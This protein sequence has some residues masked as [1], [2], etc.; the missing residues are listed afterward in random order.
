MLQ[1]IKNDLD[2]MNVELYLQHVPFVFSK[3]HT[4]AFPNPA[5]AISLSGHPP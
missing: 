2:P 4:Q 5:L 1:T 3:C